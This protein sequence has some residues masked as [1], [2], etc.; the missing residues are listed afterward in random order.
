MREFSRGMLIYAC[1]ITGPCKDVS[2]YCWNYDIS[3]CTDPNY[4]ESQN[5]SCKLSC[6]FCGKTYSAQSVVTCAFRDRKR[7]KIIIIIQHVCNTY[8]NLLSHTCL[9]IQFSFINNVALF[10][11]CTSHN[12]S[13]HVLLRV[14][15]IHAMIL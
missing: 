7:I 3:E 1:I 8:F 11:A 14:N 5:A 12:R 15:F 4:M 2:E 10:K 9:L 6:H 13:I